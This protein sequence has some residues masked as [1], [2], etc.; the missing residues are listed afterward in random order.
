MHLFRET[1]GGDVYAAGSADEA[2][3][4]AVGDT[5][6]LPEELNIEAV[7]DDKVI[8]VDCDGERVTKTAREW[9]AE[10]K[11]PGCVFGENY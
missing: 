1:E 5:G 8:T 7:P 6:A 2:L 11:E 9:A 4:M 3:K 10:A